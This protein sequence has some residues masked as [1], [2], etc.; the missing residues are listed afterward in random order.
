[1]LK[2]PSYIKFKYY[3]YIIL[4]ENKPTWMIV[5]LIRIH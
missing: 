2:K 1:M 3:K 4:Y 5:E